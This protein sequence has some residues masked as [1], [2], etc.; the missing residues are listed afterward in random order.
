MSKVTFS[1]LGLAV[2][3]AGIVLGQLLMMTLA[4]YWPKEVG[5]QVGDT[6]CLEYG[7]LHY[8]HPFD[9]SDAHIDA[10]FCGEVVADE[11][12]RFPPLGSSTHLAQ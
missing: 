12:E 10:A 8:P 6:I 5:I 7:T 9:G 3:L 1:I 4:T 2:L 11:E